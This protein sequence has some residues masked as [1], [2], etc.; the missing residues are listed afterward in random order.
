MA[1]TVNKNA[2]FFSEI[3]RGKPVNAEHLRAAGLVF[4]PGKVAELLSIDTVKFREDPKSGSGSTISD[5]RDHEA[6]KLKLIDGQGQNGANGIDFKKCLE[7]KRCAR[8]WWHLVM[9]YQLGEDGRIPS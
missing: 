6:V 4:G 3:K 8:P 1:K 2:S 9:G 7:S 5:T